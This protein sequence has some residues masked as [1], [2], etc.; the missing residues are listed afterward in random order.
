M[1]MLFVGAFAV[2]MFPTHRS[3]ALSGVPQCRMA[4]MSLTEKNTAEQKRKHELDKLVSGMSF[5]AGTGEVSANEATLW[6]IHETEK[7]IICT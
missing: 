6:Y 7:E 4:V 3:E 2:K 5:R 1:F